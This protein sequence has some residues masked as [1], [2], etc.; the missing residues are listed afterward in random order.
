[1]GV[2]TNLTPHSEQKMLA[3]LCSFGRNE[4]VH[5]FLFNAIDVMTGLGATESL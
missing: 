5:F 2:F 1:M 3:C 4:K